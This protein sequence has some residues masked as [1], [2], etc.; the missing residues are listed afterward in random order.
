MKIKLK[1]NSIRIKILVPI[2]LLL[3]AGMGISASISH[4][5]ASSALESA[6]QQS[7]RQQSDSAIVNINAW[8]RDRKLDVGNWGKQDIFLTATKETFLG[9][10]ARKKAGAVL[11]G[12]KKDYGYYSNIGLADMNGEILVAD[13]MELVGKVNVK[14]RSYFKE[15]MN[16]KTFISKVLVSKSSQAPMFVIST[17]VTSGK[18][19]AGVLVATVNL[20][21]MN[22]LFVDPI[23]T[24]ETGYA[25]MINAKG[26]VIAYPDKSRILK[27][28]ISDFDFGKTI[29]DKKNG[30]INYLYE[31]ISKLVV[32]ASSDELGW[33]L[34]V[35]VPEA[36][37][38]TEVVAL[39]R[40]NFMVTTITV[41]VASFVIFFIV[42][43]ITGRLNQV[44]AG[45]R[46][47]AE[48]EG[49]LTKRIEIKAN[50][51]VGELAQWFNAFVIK[52]QEI[53]GQVKDDAGQLNTSSHELS[54]L[55]QGMSEGADKTSDKAA[56]VTTATGEVNN[57][58]SSVASA[59]EEASSNIN[60][61]A[62]A[63][64]EMTATINE[65]AENASV[66][67]TTTN[68]AVEQVSSASAQVTELGQSARDIGSVVEAITDISEQVNLLALNATIE[69]ARAGEAGKGFAVVANEI[70][71]LALQT[72]TAAGE[73]K[74]R[75]SG[76]Q[77]STGGT[78]TEIG[79]INQATQKINAIMETIATAVEEQSATTREIADNVNQAS[80]GISE[81]NENVA[82]SSMSV[83]GISREISEVTEAAGQITESSTQVS[84][85]AADLTSLSDHLNQM[86]A[87]FKV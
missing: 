47:A 76:I 16:G 29:L 30:V 80:M 48:G 44:V 61:V 1:L 66:A 39:G 3:V 14:G 51:E 11:A 86:V 28:N 6:I 12:L 79:N 31:G 35:T 43:L 19:V 85:K 78:V 26:L 55:S 68:E 82:H 70:K 57:N 34:A 25:Y 67:L 24:G 23:K 46:D 18:K 9:K 56:S 8:I 53:I 49:D 72:S 83:D 10:A 87:R 75:V 73:I 4:I 77:Q 41:I 65:I 42:N 17:P 38:M 58:F 71:A 45:L 62:S 84:Q 15:A 60:M 13:N 36:E 59:M 40:I 69:A 32:F 63:A 37:I 2:I 22:S 21:S 20:A 5:R 64:E 81:V 7:L 54:L 27:L 50:D 74:T 33:I 52:I